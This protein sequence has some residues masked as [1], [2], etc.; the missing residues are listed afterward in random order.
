[1]FKAFR[2][3]HFYMILYVMTYS[4][5]SCLVTK[6]WIHG[7][8]ICMYVYLLLFHGNSGYLNAHQCYIY[9]YIPCLVLFKFYRG[10][11]GSLGNVLRELT[12]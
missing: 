11:Q 12:W 3:V 1:M 7:M 5:S 6:L 4:T 10:I 8:Y 9:M 2:N